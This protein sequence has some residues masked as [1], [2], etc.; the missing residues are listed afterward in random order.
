MKVL[1][2]SA[3]KSEQRSYDVAL[4]KKRKNLFSLSAPMINHFGLRFLKENVPG[5]CILEY[6]SRDEYL[7]RLNE[8]WDVVG[9]SF[10]INETND[11][12][13]MANLARRHNIRQVWAGNYG[14]FT[15]SIQQHFDRT[16]SGWGEA[17]LAEA[18]GQEITALKH[19]PLFM[20]MKYRDIKLQTWGVLFTSRGCNKSCTFCQTPA[21]YRKPHILDLRTLEEVVLQYKK[22]GVEQVIILDENF[23]Y[24][25]D[26]TSREVIGL[27]RKYGL[28][29]NPL[30]RVET[31][32][33]NYES[34]VREGLCGASLGVESLNQ[35]SLDGARKGNDV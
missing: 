30:T 22:I 25:E 17:P 11:A 29:W 10:Y 6:P 3:W 5:V 7:G 32:S 12:I 28:K 9:I 16:F 18:V 24:F 8:G 21:F 23:G 15:P 14:A 31:L 13:E 2:S 33:K 4:W 27:L 26:F 1:I 20:E 19:P 34:W 35:A